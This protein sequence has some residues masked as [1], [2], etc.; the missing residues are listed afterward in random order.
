MEIIF[1]FILIILVYALFFNAFIVLLEIILPIWLI[2]KLIQLVIRGIKAL[3][4]NSGN[5]GF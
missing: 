4:D 5:G 3:I 2:Y 1:A